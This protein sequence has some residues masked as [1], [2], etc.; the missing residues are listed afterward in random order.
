MFEQF[1]EFSMAKVNRLLLGERITLVGLVIAV[2]KN[3]K[4]FCPLLNCDFI[5]MF[6][7]V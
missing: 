7:K 5:T 4:T 1:S 2:N 6:K 3:K